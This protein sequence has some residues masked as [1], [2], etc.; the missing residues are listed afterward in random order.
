MWA[1]SEGNGRDHHKHHIITKIM[2]AQC[3]LNKQAGS[4][5]CAFAAQEH[6]R[7]ELP[8]RAF[9]RGVVSSKYSSQLLTRRS[10]SGRLER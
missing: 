10:L 2:T 9:M 7:A 6:L 1:L 4:T 5:I 8:K 3:I